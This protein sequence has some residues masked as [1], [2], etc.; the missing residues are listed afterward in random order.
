MIVVVFRAHAGE[1]CVVT[2]VGPRSCDIEIIDYFQARAGEVCV[3]TGVGLLVLMIF[4]K[5]F[6]TNVVCLVFVH[7]YV[8]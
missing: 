1:V 2:R 5:Q 3:V 6:I 7:S 4:N 8:L